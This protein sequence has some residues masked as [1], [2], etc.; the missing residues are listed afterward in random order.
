MA[1]S[2]FNST[3]FAKFDVPSTA[4]VTLN[5]ITAM[6]PTE[7]DTIVN[8][9]TELFENKGKQSYGEDVTQLEHMVQSGFLAAE[10]GYDDE[11]VIAAF[12]H[13]I[14]HICIDHRG[15]DSMGQFGA[16]RH[17]QIGADYLR[18]RGFSE[19]IAILI[20]GHVG[21]KRYLTHK[22][23]EYLSKLSEASLNTLKYQG[24]PMTEEEAVAFENGPYFDLCIK[25]RE[26]DDAGKRVDLDLS[27]ISP[28]IDR[29]R[30]YLS[31]Q[32]EVHH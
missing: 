6:T 7:I 8:E 11:V 17:E 31:T 23:P 15:E 14:G 12:L 30:T 5:Y 4:P 28:F 24:G 29:V 10:E 13:D 27:D 18:E 16:R 32:S 2:Y 25:M 3:P 9:I 1:T 22:H 20:E 19:K 26:W 21:A